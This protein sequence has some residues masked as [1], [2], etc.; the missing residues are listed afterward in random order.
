MPAAIPIPLALGRFR[1]LPQRDS[2]VWQGGLVRMPVWI[3]DP[4]SGHPPY[5]PTG[6]IW[7]SLRTGRI[8][9]QLPDEASEPSSQLALSAL[10]EFAA[11][12]TK[13]LGGRPSRIQVGDAGLQAALSTA[14][15]GTNT[16]IERV[17]DLAA[18]HQVLEQLERDQGSGVSYPGLL[19]PRGVTVER[20]R[21]FADAAARFYEARPWQHLLNEDLIVAEAAGAP[22]GMAHLSVLGNG[23]Q[24]FGIALYR[25]RREFERV[26]EI[27][28]PRQMR[29]AFGVTFGPPTEL[30]FA[31]ADLWEDHALPLAG[32]QAY[33]VVAD[34]RADRIL[35]PGAKALTHL[36]AL[37]RALAETTEDDLDA[38]RWRREV[39]TFDGSVVLDLSLPFLLEAEQGAPTR[40]TPRT[41]TTPGPAEQTLASLGRLLEQ[42]AY[43]SIEEMNEVLQRT[44]ADRPRGGSDDTM[45]G[46]RPLTAL[47]QAQELMYDAADATGRLR[48]KLARRAVAISPDC[49]DAYVALGD[50]ASTPEAARD[51]YQ[52][53]VEAGARAIG[54]AR[55][56]E[57]AGEFWGHIE[58]RPYMR[59]RLALAEALRRLGANED[60]LGHYHGLLQLNPGDN[61]GVRYLLLPALLE[62]GHDSEAGA[63]LERYEDDAQA[64]WPYARALWL[65][66]RD[67]DSGAARAA[68]Q[69]ALEANAYVAGFL[70]APETM[71]WAD[72]PSFVLGSVEEATDVARGLAPAFD[73]TPDA[74]A[75]L[76]RNLSIASR[77]PGS[78]PSA[79]ARRKRRR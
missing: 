36:E 78:R 56:E 20:V 29:P 79:G 45:P 38:A 24:Q 2:E 21:A 64:A 16:G 41:G 15:A 54:Q 63:L 72:A 55:F 47:E 67:G 43:D 1:L 27:A 6:A 35:R 51:W 26:L 8:N 17:D 12:E 37:L 18:V 57:L 5:R 66:R 31:D 53:G 25:S 50:A 10:F 11:K 9:L 49:A 68:L 76:G 42:G 62:A 70:L 65:F 48:I 33:P 14:L 23:G 32:P 61:Q 46:G 39:T 58:T 71:P 7:V 52:R 4:T 34:F 22:R 30:A 60:A 59:A 44:T 75:W 28:D 19:G 40:R 13:A 3:D 73:R 74:L 77:R 69:E